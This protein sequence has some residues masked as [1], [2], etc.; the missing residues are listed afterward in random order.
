M[1]GGIDAHAHIFNA[2]DL[3]IA[4]FIQKVFLKDYEERDL[5]KWLIALIVKNLLQSGVMSA[6][7]EYDILGSVPAL[8]EEAIDDAD[9]KSV[10]ALAEA[11]RAVVLERPE[12]FILPNG[13][14]YL[15]DFSE[16][17]GGTLTV[18]AA[19]A[20]SRA[21]KEIL[22]R[23]LYDAA[24]LPYRNPDEVGGFATEDDYRPL[25]EALLEREATTDDAGPLNTVETS[26]ITEQVWTYIKWAAVLRQP[27]M[28]ILRAYAGRYGGGD[29]IAAVAPSLVDYEQWLE[30][31]PASPFL[32][33]VMVMDRIQQ[34]APARCG[35][36]LHSLVPYDPLRQARG[37]PVAEDG[38]SALD[39]VKDAVF[40]HGFVG[41]KIYPPMGFRPRGNADNPRFE[42]SGRK[43]DEALDSLFAWADDQGVPIMTHAL[44]SQA[45]STGAGEHAAPKHWAQV[46]S[47]FER[48]RLN[49]GH[50]GDFDEVG[51]PDGPWE[52]QAA[53]L[54]AAHD[55]VYA[56]M[57]YL[58]SALGAAD[59]EVRAERLGALAAE[60][61]EPDGP[62]LEHRLMYGS[63]Y[64]MIGQAVGH[65]D[66]LAEWR[67]FMRLAFVSDDLARFEKWN[68]VAF[69]GLDRD[70]PNR[71]RLHG[72][73]SR[74]GLDPTILSAFDQ[75]RY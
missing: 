11:M 28:G 65:P 39:L 19:N 69:F 23:A 36:I 50:F 21:D 75:E 57:G 49:L 9:R 8:M 26:G 47:D 55:N 54:M 42:V 33:Q 67:R 15:P 20:A 44:R 13:D 60:F 40:D 27:R 58:G 61:A 72:W 71:R 2:T 73:Y 4:G 66:Y 70:G 59:M 35:M 12:D 10:D 45:A 7:R 34:H 56:D 16:G 24:D 41:V 46:L 43:L 3:S 6:A 29:A 62:L 5:G 38:R 30:D 1:T 14:S 18:D 52:R 74:H 53:E 51:D 68:A 64:S 25:A 22:F 48:L 63:D 17:A 31:K 37:E 32:D